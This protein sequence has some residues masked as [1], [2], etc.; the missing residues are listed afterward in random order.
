MGKS[1][2]KFG[3]KVS[4]REKPKEDQSVFTPLKENELF[5]ERFKV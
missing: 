4:E 5:I 3:A 1:I 2:E